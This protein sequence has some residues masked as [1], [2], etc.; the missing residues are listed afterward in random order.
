MDL[1]WG[2]QLALLVASVREPSEE[3]NVLNFG[4]SSRSMKWESP[5]TIQMGV[6]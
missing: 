3:S 1:T 4:F 2:T 6:S 5:S